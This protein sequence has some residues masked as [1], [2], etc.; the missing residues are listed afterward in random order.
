MAPS[1]DTS[2]ASGS[3]SAVLAGAPDSGAASKRHGKSKRLLL[4]IVLAVVIAGGAAAF[5]Y[6]K[7]VHSHSGVQNGPILQ[8]SSSTLNLADGH[9]LE[10]AIACQLTT[11]ANQ[12]DIDPLEP[13]LF[14]AEISVFSGF[15]YPE[16]LGLPGKS[17]AKAQLLKEFQAIVGTSGKYQQ[18]SEVYFT[19]FIMQ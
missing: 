5:F 17:L 19:T 14:N 15:T 8:L 6:P 7:L 2:S 10:I 3:G 11:A 9:I 1:T 13:R 12:K 4:S 18:I 16:L